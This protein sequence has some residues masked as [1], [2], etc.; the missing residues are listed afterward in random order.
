[1]A[2]RACDAAQRELCFHAGRPEANSVPTITD[3]TGLVW[4]EIDGS[5]HTTIFVSTDADADA[6]EIYMP[7]AVQLH[8]SDFI[9]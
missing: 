4:S 9:L 3:W 8:A 7:Q 6:D 1:V 5:G 2:D